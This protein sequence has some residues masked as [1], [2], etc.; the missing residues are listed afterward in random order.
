MYDAAFTGLRGIHKLP[1]NTAERKNAYWWYPIILDLD[2]LDTDAKGIRVELSSLKIPCYGIQ[3]PEAYKEKAYA[4][5]RG[6]G[7]ADFPFHSREYTDPESV[8]YTECSC[9]VAHSLRARTVSLFL[10][11][12]WEEVHI[13][14]CIDGMRS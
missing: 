1:V 8:K 12:S 7:E 2:A 3:W 11:P 10:H 5:L 13:Q 9:P 14:R 4:E 6:F